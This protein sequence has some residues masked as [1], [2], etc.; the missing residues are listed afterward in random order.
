[1]ENVRFLAL[2]KTSVFW[3]KNHCFI[4]Y[5][6]RYL[7]KIHGVTPLENVHFLA[8]FKTSIFWYKNRCFQSKRS[9]KIS[10]LVLFI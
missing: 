10:Y 6:V 1:M 9:K 3:S 5:Q 4:Q 8:L 2:F 7:D